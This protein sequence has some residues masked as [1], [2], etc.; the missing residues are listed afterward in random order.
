M[1][2][3]LKL[4]AGFAAV[5]MVLIAVVLVR[6]Q[7]TFDAPYP[8]IHASFDPKVIDRGRYIAY[9]AG[10]CVNCHTSHAEAKD[11]L[12]GKQPPMAG[13]LSF[14]LP[15]G[16]FYTPNL[17]PD[18]TTGI[19]RFSDQE[20]ARVIRYGV[21][22]DNKAALPFMEFH[23]L[24]DEDLTAIIS[25]LRSQP[26]VRREIPDNRFN[27]LGK[28]VMAFVIKPAGPSHPVIRNSPPMEATVAR[29][30]YLATSVATCSECHTKRNP[31]DGS[32]V[33]AKFSGG[34]V[35]PIEGDN[36]HVLVTPN[37]TPSKWG[38]ITDWDEER[39]VGRLNAGVGIVGTHMPWAQFASMTDT[40]KRAI[41]RYLRTLPPSDN[42]PGPS[43]QSKKE[44]KKRRRDPHRPAPQTAQARRKADIR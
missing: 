42:D 3:A 25:F 13:G 32:Y 1:R 39:F 41:Y 33:A 37:L 24:S 35:L 16:I 5:V 15:V 2:I 4:L 31:V 28:A 10:H 14:D 44:L 7:R 34:G 22:P 29:G 40:D 17:T 26:A 38:R 12:A 30:Q 9:G 27:F 19:G 20:L 6:Y 43:V 36:E 23:D 11:V 8:D 18:R 21:M